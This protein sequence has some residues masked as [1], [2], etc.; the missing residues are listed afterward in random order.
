M[1][2]TPDADLLVVG[3][4]VLG[5]S[6]AW[7]ARSLG[8]TVCVLDVSMGAPSATPSSAGVLWPLEPLAADSPFRPW[9]EQALTLYPQFLQSLTETPEAD[10]GYVRPGLLRLDARPQALEPGEEWAAPRWP[11]QAEAVQGAWVPQ[12]ARIDPPKM[13]ACLRGRLLAAKV[14]ILREQAV[15]VTDAAEVITATR[16]LRGQRVVMASGA[17]SL[18]GDADL[19]PVAGQMLHLRPHTPYRGPMLVEGEAYVVPLP[20]G[21]VLLGATLEERD[22]ATQVTAWGLDWLL[23]QLPSFAKLIGPTALHWQWLGLRPRY[24]RGQRPLIGRPEPGSR[25]AWANGAYRLGMTIAP[26]VAQQVAAWAS[27]EE[28][29]LPLIR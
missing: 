28:Q 3:G 18:R 20:N 11:G 9:V 12:A 8:M 10:C 21:D 2:D 29:A 23:S 13:L 17:W 5:L 25:V 1:R 6:V 15:R 22:Y 7:Q 16:R 26:A 24:A 14:P 27:G 19:V 4:G